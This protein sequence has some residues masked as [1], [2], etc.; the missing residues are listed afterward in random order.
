[1]KEYM[2]YLDEKISACRA[3]IAALQA[4]GREDDAVFAKVRANIYDVFKTVSRVHLNR[5][6][7]GA[8]A[9][10]AML[11]KFQKEWGEALQLAETHGD[12]QKIAVEEAKLAVLADVTA[13]FEESAGV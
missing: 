4:D 1:M 3:E 6:G 13:R 11:K 8:D 7:G 2:N 10:R 5:P 9:V 12:T